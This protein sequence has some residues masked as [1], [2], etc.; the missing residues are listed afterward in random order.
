[1]DRISVDIAYGAIK[2]LRPPNDEVTLTGLEGCC[3]LVAP[4]LPSLANSLRLFSPV[5]Y[6]RE[7]FA[8]SPPPVST[9]RTTGRPNGER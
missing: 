9:V 6:R 3:Y 2:K 1:M 4:L 8:L 5:D 7:V